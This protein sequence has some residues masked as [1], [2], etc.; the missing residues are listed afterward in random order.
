VSV[1]WI[2]GALFALAVFGLAL[3]A[4][5]LARRGS[6]ALDDDDDATWQQRALRA[7]ARAEV[8]E[9]AVQDGAALL[10]ILETL[11]E[12]NLTLRRQLETQAGHARPDA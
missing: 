7:E 11:R 9:Q 8:A 1:E 6:F 4:G 5:W 3:A 10:D 2:N 12:E